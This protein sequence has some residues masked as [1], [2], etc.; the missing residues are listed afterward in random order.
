MPQTSRVWVRQRQRSDRHRGRL[1]PLDRFR[2][3]VADFD[4]DGWL[5]IFISNGHV[6]YESRGS[7]YF[8]PPK[9]LRNEQGKRFAD[10]S[11]RG[12]PYFSISHA[13]RGIA[14]GDLDN[15]GALDVV[16]SRMDDP[17]V[18]LRNRLSPG[19]NWVRVEL[20]ST[21]SNTD[22]VGAKLTAIYRGRVLTRW[23]RGGGGVL[24]LFRSSRAFS[25][26]ERYAR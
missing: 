7:P 2:H 1:P 16:I 24:L 25:G 10:I 8:Q 26:R 13:G 15:D 6:W 9:L 3:R 11:A 23:I 18:V 4:N 19:K 5:D 12:G 22:A 14:V 17:V 20:R 21:E